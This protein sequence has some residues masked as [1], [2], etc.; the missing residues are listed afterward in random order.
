[1]HAPPDSIVIKANSLNCSHSQFTSMETASISMVHGWFS[2]CTIA[3]NT[4]PGVRAGIGLVA[5]MSSLHMDN[6]LISNNNVIVRV[7]EQVSV[8]AP[9][10]LDQFARGEFINCL[11]V[12][13]A[14]TISCCIEN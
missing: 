14:V 2:H 1:M 4:G 11:F 3:N 8:F 12:Q 5:A 7:L 10:S 9:I 6:C 13:N